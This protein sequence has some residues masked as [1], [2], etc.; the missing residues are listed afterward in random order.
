MASPSY[1]TPELPGAEDAQA[2]GEAA[3]R[4][5]PWAL[6]NLG[7]GM[8]FLLWAATGWHAALTNTQLMFAAQRGWLSPGATLFPFIVL[9]SLTV[10]GLVLLLMGLV[11]VR[12]IIAW[13]RD[14]DWAQHGYAI[15]LVLSLLTYVPVMQA[16]GFLPAT[17]L[18]CC[19]WLFTLSRRIVRDAF[20]VMAVALIS[21]A[22]I[23]GLIHLVF[24]QLVRVP[25]P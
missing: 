13:D 8:F 3:T 21:S 11:R 22:L 19:A 14:I 23:A 16:I 9:T 2:Q 1:H 25:L 17:L 6:V 18:F 15:A 5:A 20:R 7:T 10:G 24:V 12:S 4:P